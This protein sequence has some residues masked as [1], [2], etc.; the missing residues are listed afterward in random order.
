M[1]ARLLPARGSIAE[2]YAESGD[3]SYALSSDGGIIQPLDVESIIARWTSIAYCGPCICSITCVGERM[4]LEC[5]AL[6][7]GRE[8]D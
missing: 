2:S 5:L 7:V 6:V 1:R 8:R 4:A 3:E